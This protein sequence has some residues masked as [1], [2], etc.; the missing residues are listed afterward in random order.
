MLEVSIAL[1]LLSVLAG[2]CI[3]MIAGLLPGVHVNNTSAILLGLSPGMLAAGIEPLYIAITIVSSTISQ[4]FLDIIPAVFLGAPD[5]STVLAVMPGHRLLLDGLGEE[6]VRLSA[7]GSGLAIVISLLLIVPL[8]MGFK[9]ALPVLQANMSLILIAIAAFVILTNYQGS[10]YLSVSSRIRKV[11]WALLIFLTAGAL[12]IASFQAEYL[13]SPVLSL[14]MPSVLLPLL[15]GLFGMPPLLLSLNIQ[16]VL[17]AQRR[18]KITMSAGDILRASGAGTVAGA[19]VSWFPAVSAGVA[20]SIVSLFSTKEG[21]TDRKYLVSVSCVNT[22]NDIFSLVALY[23]IMRPR[24][25]AVAAA[26]EVLGGSIGYEAFVIFLFAICIA[27]VIAYLLTLVAGSC[28]ARIF[29]A[30]DYRLL[31]WGVM[32]FLA[33]MCIVMTG[34]PGLAIFLIAAAVGLSAHLVNVRKTCLM[35]V[36]MVPCILYF[37]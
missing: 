20:T 6:A 2:I 19:L 32:V 14:G 23:V 15:S 28:A 34:I 13:L 35:G 16:S 7:I 12:G 33:I 10:R 18:S 30:L 27:G 8:S 3:G 36:L 1:L 24:S 25:G 11:C 5:E 4:S 9:T 37:L 22:S 31:N 26:Q 21:D 29:S 17:P